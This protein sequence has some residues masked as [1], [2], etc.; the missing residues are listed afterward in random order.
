M[1]PEVLSLPEIHERFAGQQVLVRVTAW[2][3]NNSP[4][5]GELIAHGTAK[6]VNKALKAV[7]RSGNPDYPYYVF[8]AFPSVPSTEEWRAILARAAEVGLPGTRRH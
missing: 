3:T 8:T 5:H 1:E 2:D 4:S 7:P 6:I